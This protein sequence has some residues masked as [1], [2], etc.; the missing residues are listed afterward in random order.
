MASDR[1]D[2][3]DPLR[4]RA[5]ARLAEEQLGDGAP[6]TDDLHRLIHELEVHRV[7]L[8]MQ[9]EELRRVERDLEQSRDRWRELYDYAPVGYLTLDD[10][11]KIVE[12]NL[13]A[14]AM[15]GT[16]RGRLIGH[17]LARFMEPCDA[18]AFHR[19]VSDTLATS[20]KQTCE[21]PLRGA[22]DRVFVAHFDSVAAPGPDG[23]RMLCR[24]AFSDVSALRDAQD[25]VQTQES[26]LRALLDRLPDAVIG[27]DELGRIRSFNAAAERVF[28]FR[29]G[30]VLGAKVHLLFAMNRRD[31]IEQLLR[32]DALSDGGGAA[33]STTHATFG[34][35][36][37]GSEFPAELGL[38]RWHDQG[39]PR[40]KLVV[41]DVT[42]RVHAEQELRQ[43]ELR[44]RQIAEHVGDAFFVRELD[45]TLSYVNPGF[46]RITGRRAGD[47]ARHGNAWLDAIHD[48]DRPGFVAAC[49]RM[50][51]DAAL[52]Q[53]LRVRRPDGTIRHVRVRGFTVG[54]EHGTALR[55]VFVGQDV[56]TE[57]E[58]EERLR[59]SQRMEAI[60][61]LAAGIAHDFGNVLQAIMG[62]LHVALRE[63]T[64][65]ERTRE[66]LQ[67][68]E[69]TASRGAGLI[70]Q[71]T[72]FGRMQKADIEQVRFDDLIEESAR[73]L[74]RLLGEHIALAIRT[75]APGAV[76]DA[77]PVELQ[78]ILLNL[79]TNA[80]DAMPDG[81]TLTIETEELSLDEE[82]AR[83]H[84]LARPGCYVR[85]IVTD[86]GTGMDAVTRR[87]SFD[88][89][90]TTKP[91]GE[92]TGLGLSTVFASVRELGGSIE[93]ESEVGV[94]TRFIVLLPARC[95][96]EDAIRVRGLG[97]GDLRGTALVVEDEPLVRTTLRTYLEELGLD[98]VE[99]CD[100]EQALELDQQRSQGLALL[101]TDVVM[102]RMMGPELA[103]RL[104]ERHPGLRVLYVSAHSPADLVERGL[105][106]PDAALLR[107]P[108]DRQALATRLRML[109]PAAA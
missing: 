103:R 76:V 85:M 94:G 87:R 65:S 46:E 73:L 107:K 42:E 78:R 91:V 96:N 11:G 18:D 66:F 88:P 81:G 61:T 68:A 64:L 108:F 19:H 53:E 74:E 45:G 5:E 3:R 37:D 41:R 44:F 77:V 43:S 29:E 72:S 60:G 93:V 22:H 4:Q 32:A 71:I 33:R 35:R 40:C 39:K 95:G 99:A 57:H 51:T 58:L 102:P 21:L 27:V 38:A 7:E 23:D 1:G 90:F 10:G 9:N 100:G 82:E 56:T 20:S 48:E 69:T 62:C 97:S 67:R 101:L 92:G 106:A 25:R 2:V 75:R 13:T 63:R 84:V 79:T 50:D 89:F 109:L 6:E 83:R 98:V 26:R 24:T 15:I 86:T 31:Q 104:A 49:E 55:H 30:Q 14:A 80:R 8:Q 16:E 54:D 70:Y 47:I 34:L 36:P 52:D 59:H 28:G 105:V 12:C 17:H